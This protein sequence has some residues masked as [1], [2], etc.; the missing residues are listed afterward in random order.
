VCIQVRFQGGFFVSVRGL[1]EKLII[2]QDVKL[3]VVAFSKPNIEAL[4]AQLSDT[5]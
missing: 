5:K 3:V 1:C 4:L 2:W